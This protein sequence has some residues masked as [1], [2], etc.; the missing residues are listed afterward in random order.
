MVSFAKKLDRLVK[1]KVKRKSTVFTNSFAPL[2]ATFPPM[3][4]VT[5]RV[6]VMR[7]PQC[8]YV[9]VFGDGESRGRRCGE[10]VTLRHL[11]HAPGVLSNRAP[12]LVD[13]SMKQPLAP[14]H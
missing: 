14:K 2:A 3:F 7:A 9:A 12:R 4:I 13:Y 1:T 8:L 11:R 5:L 6:L 10:L